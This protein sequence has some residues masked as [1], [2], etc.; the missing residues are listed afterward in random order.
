MHNNSLKASSSIQIIFFRLEIIINFEKRYFVC[1]TFS[2]L[3]WRKLNLNF[4][5]AKK[6]IKILK[7]KQPE[8]SLK[9]KK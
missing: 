7:E 4:N 9:Q 2:I 3:S 5:D 1:H 6:K 8:E